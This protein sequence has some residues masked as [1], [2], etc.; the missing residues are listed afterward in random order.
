MPENWNAYDTCRD[1]K[2]AA[3]TAIYFTGLEKKIAPLTLRNLLGDIAA[4]D[5]HNTENIVKLTYALVE[6]APDQTCSWSAHAQSLRWNNQM[7]EAETAAKKGLEINPRCIELLTILGKLYL[8]KKEYVKAEDVLR[9][10]FEINPQYGALPFCEALI[11]TGSLDE[12]EKRLGDAVRVSGRTTSSEA[13]SYVIDLLQGNGQK[14]KFLQHRELLHQSQQSDLFGAGKIA[15]LN[16]ELAD[17][18]KAHP[19]LLFEPGNTATAQGR[20]AFLHDL[21]PARLM[22]AIIG[23]FQAE[24]ERFFARHE[25]HEFMNFRP[26]NLNITSWAVVLEKGGYQHTHTHPNGWLSGVYYVDVGGENSEDGNGGA[27]EFLKPPKSLIGD[28]EPE[29]IVIKPQNGVMLL[30]PSHFYHHTI[31]HTGEK[32]RVTISFDIN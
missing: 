21:L 27:I 8:E 28:A 5:A 1:Q 12:A 17:C 23:M 31:P 30:F 24:A 16:Q 13:L 20:Q 29:T 18:L 3:L 26:E 4:L 19:A 2:R 15:R 9:Q 7:D 11:K 6:Y 14:N 22:D 32:E 10:A 25:Q